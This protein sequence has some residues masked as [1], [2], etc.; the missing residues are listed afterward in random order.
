MVNL[1]GPERNTLIDAIVEPDQDLMLLDL[2]GDN[3]GP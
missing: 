3:L 1:A 2:G